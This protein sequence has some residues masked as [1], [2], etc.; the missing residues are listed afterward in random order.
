ML[1][2]KEWV[3]LIVGL[4]SPKDSFSR[5]W[6]PAQPFF[7]SFTTKDEELYKK[8]WIMQMGKTIGVVYV[9]V[10]FFLTYLSGGAIVMWRWVTQNLSLY[11]SIAMFQCVACNIQAWCVGCLVVH[12]ISMTVG[13]NF[14]G[15]T[16]DDIYLWFS[17]KITV[18]SF[19]IL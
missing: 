16:L 4:I 10:T 3:W 9:C 12:P 1:N 14:R 5:L 15:S 19:V 6:I 18:F 2:R 11:L 17:G 7:L 13:Q 8:K